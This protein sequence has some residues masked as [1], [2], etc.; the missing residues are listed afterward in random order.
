MTADEVIAA[1][2]AELGT[3]FMHQGRLPG[4]ALDCAGLAVVVARHWYDVTEPAAYSR[5]P[6]NGQLEYWIEHQDFIERVTSAPVAG[7]LLLMRFGNEPQHIAFCAGDTMIHSYS[8][9]GKVTEHRFSDVWQARVVRVYRF[10]D[11]S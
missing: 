9:V 8:N 2:R 6:S 5:G 7:N 1:A 11:L 4:I 10:K 3:P